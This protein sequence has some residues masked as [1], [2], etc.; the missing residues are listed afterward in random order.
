MLK[1][2]AALACADLLQSYRVTS[3]LRSTITWVISLLTSLPPSLVSSREV[4]ALL[5]NLLQDQLVAGHL[6]YPLSKEHIKSQIFE[7]RSLQA[8]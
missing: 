2:L 8:L 1:G 3:L 7:R 5:E 4:V 6:A